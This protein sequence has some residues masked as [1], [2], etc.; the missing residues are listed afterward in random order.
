MYQ[1]GLTATKKKI[2]IYISPAGTVVTI[3]SDNFE[4]EEGTG[5]MEL[6]HSARS[7]NTWCHNSD[8]YSSRRAVPALQR[9]VVGGVCW[10]NSTILAQHC[11]QAKVLT[12]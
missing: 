6:E 8:R 10:S 9:T 1:K 12:G 3:T 4:S 2:Y 7:E 5:A 11:S